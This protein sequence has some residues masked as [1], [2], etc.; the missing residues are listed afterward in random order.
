MGDNMQAL[1][2]WTLGTGQL[3]WVYEYGYPLVALKH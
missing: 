2:D 3:L 1:C